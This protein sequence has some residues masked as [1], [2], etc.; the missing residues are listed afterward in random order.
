MRTEKEQL[1]MKTNGRIPLRFFYAES[2]SFTLPIQNKALQ[3]ALF[4]FSTKKLA[5]TEGRH[6]LERQ[7]QVR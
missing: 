3:P 4:P 1:E 6:E 2:V 7:L 5:H